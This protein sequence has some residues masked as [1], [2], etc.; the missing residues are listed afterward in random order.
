MVASPPSRST[1]TLAGRLHA[2]QYLRIMAALLV[3]YH[4][5]VIQYEP[6]S[7]VLPE[8]G[9]FGV[10]VFF[11]VSGF[12]M[13]HAT[14]PADTPVRFLAR[15]ALRVAPLYWFFTLLIAATLWLAPQM[16]RTVEP[17]IVA[18]LKSLAFIPYSPDGDPERVLPMLTLGWTLNYEMYFYAV[19]AAA[20]TL[21]RRSRPGAVAAILALPCLVAALV[22]SPQVALA[23]YG[24]PIVFEFVAGMLIAYRRSAAGA[25]GAWTARSVLV[26]GVASLALATALD[27]DWNRAFVYG[28]PA[29]LV[30]VG[31]LDARVPRVRWAVV[32]GDASYAL[33]LSHLFT[34]GVLRGVLPP[35]LGDGAAGALAFVL[36]ALATSVL[37][38]VGVH[39][40]VEPL[41]YG[42]VRE[43]FAQ[44]SRIL[45]ALVPTSSQPPAERRR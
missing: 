26:L 22:P 23:F 36:A 28:V 30:V 42:R 44:L 18:L 39:L 7:R 11:V 6:W 32:L 21:P 17:D 29:A 40:L 45:R 37:V 9:E 15:R 38:S 10:D 43:A 24:E 8:F 16:T 1:G 14:R 12:V 20:L 34:L 35:L 41:L 5:S 19:F 33:Y 2:L 27:L 25:L 4:H 31:A 3:V 13:V